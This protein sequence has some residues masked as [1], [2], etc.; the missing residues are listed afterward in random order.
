MA[1]TA[2][3]LAQIKDS[4][5]STVNDIIRWNGSNWA[6]STLDADLVALEGLSTTGLVVR[7][8][9]GAYTTRQLAISSITS[10][11]AALGLGNATGVSGNPTISVNTHNSTTKLSVVVATTA[12]ITLSGLQTID[13]ISVTSSNR[14]LVKNQTTP[15]QNG[16]YL[17]SSGAWS[18]D[19][20]FDTSSK[21]DNGVIV[22]VSRGTTN[23][24]KYFKLDTAPPITLGTTS[25]SFSEVLFSGDGNGIYSG[26]GTIDLSG[27]DV[28]AALSN[29][30]QTFNMSYSTTN[31]AL[32]ITNNTI[33]PASSSIQL[34][35]NDGS[36]GVYAA[37]E[38]AGIY[39]NS[40][41]EFAI[42][43]GT[44]RF[45]FSPVDAEYSVEYGT[46]NPAI[47]V[48]NDD[49]GAQAGSYVNVASPSQIYNL[50]IDDTYASIYNNTNGAEFLVNSNGVA[51]HDGIGTGT[52]GKVLTANGTGNATWEDV[53]TDGNGIYSGSGTID[54]STNVDATLSNNTGSFQIAWNNGSPILYA[55][56]D[57]TTP[58]N[59]IVYLSAESENYYISV[60]DSEIALSGIGGGL[61]L[62]NTGLKLSDGV[63]GYGTAGKVLTSDGTYALWQDPVVDGN[64]IYTG[65]G[66]IPAGT[67]ATL[68]SGEEFSIDYSNS[69]SSI[70]ISDLLGSTKISSGAGT[71]SVFVQDAII[72]IYS[73]GGYTSFSGGTSGSEVRFYEPSGSGTNYVSFTAPVLAANTTYIWPTS[74]TDGYYLK[75]NTGG[76]LEWAAVPGGTPAGSNTYIQYNNSGAFGAEAAFTYNPSTDTMT[77]SN[78]VL[79]GFSEWLYATNSLNLSA[80]SS[81]N[82]IITLSDSSPWLSLSNAGYTS[83][84]TNLDRV[85][86]S[87]SFA[88]TSAGT[89]IH[90]SLVI[91][92][93]INQTGTHSGETFGLVIAPTLTSI[94]SNFYGI[95]VDINDANA[96]GVLQS[97]SATPNAFSGP[98]MFGDV[99]APQSGA[100]VEINSTTGGF[101][102]PRMTTTERGLLAASPDGLVVY[103]TTDSK[104][105][106]RENGAWVEL[107]GGADGNGIYSGSGTI[108]TAAVATVASGSTFTIDWNNTT[109]ALHFADTTGLFT[110]QTSNGLNGVNSSSASAGLFSN[111]NY[112]RINATNGGNETNTSITIDGGHLSLNSIISP[113]S[114]SANQNNYAPTGIEA[115]NRVRLTSSTAVD[116]TGISTAGAFKIPGWV[117]TLHNI[118]TNAIT[119]KD[120]DANST[121]AYRFALGT[122]VVINADESF[123]LIYDNT[124]SRWRALVS[125]SV[126]VNP[127]TVT[128]ATLGSPTYSTLQDMQNIV[129]STGWADGGAVT[130]GGSGTV[131]VAAGT[132]LI[133]GTNSIP[134]TL[135]WTN[136]SA[137]TGLTLTDNATNYIYVDYNGGSPVVTASV[138]DPTGDRTKIY[139]ARVYRSG[140]HLHIFEGVRWT[141]ADHASLM[142]WSMSET[143][144]FA[145]VSGAMLTETG[146]R[147]LSLSS[148]V[149]WHGLARITT[150]ALNTSVADTF[151]L[152]YRNGVG[153]WTES[154]SQTQINN[155][156]YD[157][158]TGTLATLSNNKYGV[159][160]IYLSSESE[161]FDVLGQG[162]Y[163]LIEAQDAQVPSP[164]EELTTNARLIAKI[165]VLKSASTFTSV[166]MAYMNSFN[167]APIT[168][169]HGSLAGLSDDDHTQYALLAGRTGGQVL[170]GGTSSGDDMTIRSTT[171]A[172]KGSIIL[173]DQGGDVLIGSGAAST[174]GYS[175]VAAQA[176]KGA[177]VIQTT[178][179]G[180]LGG[181]TGSSELQLINS[182][183]T[184]GTTWY[185]HSKNTG[186]F[187][188][189][190]STSAE[191]QID[192][193]GHVNIANQLKIG[194]TTASSA[195]SIL[196]KDSSNYVVGVT[197]G[198]GLDLT[199]GTLSANQQQTVSTPSFSTNNYTLVAGDAGKMLLLSNGAT[200]GTL[201]IPPNSSVAFPTGTVIDMT[202]TGSGQIT[203]TPGS[204]VTINSAGSATK[205]RVQYSGTS[206]IKTA[207]DTWVLVGDITA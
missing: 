33:T 108:G 178:G 77:V 142:M 174:T 58:A 59:S 112:F 60:S 191:F 122:D 113:T 192:T 154:A 171:N 45:S 168:G 18:R 48:F 162:D 200:A 3:S 68:T 126:T 62:D 32:S 193:S 71:G 65:P 159:H 42:I 50:Y 75:Y 9:D 135:Y 40:A 156:Q 140:T 85:R 63:I 81:S 101:L 190:T 93:V 98:T 11:T 109:N 196:G 14:V 104:F 92:P 49:T 201:T 170:T 167:G 72:D 189:G 172:T 44:A 86:V 55:L 206:I 132:G 181:S 70:I 20:D 96:F 182:T 100:T 183:A 207:T 202:Q 161:L 26:S 173:N 78:T 119:L 6:V 121:A 99:Q 179:A 123:T 13:G 169:D 28:T 7:T 97:G 80:T 66:T 188:I 194:D 91:D 128:L 146:T 87:G 130:D 53:T 29:H 51:V 27:G 10:S 4:G 17:P 21:A 124:S 64:G 163:T 5:A 46:G 83:A 133:K 150:S 37:D 134:A 39:N 197:L 129:H 137:V 30:D 198:T 147:N 90:R 184:T 186:E 111:E 131:N 1:N 82:S 106:F 155:T 165:I 180:S 36:S 94:G 114:L 139:L 76:Q 41:G 74:A 118:G 160:W 89:N 38:Y 2:I 127:S 145:H 34:L 105:N 15:A 166:E 116:I 57:I 61:N 144:P 199:S 125:N 151:T 69:N 12:N 148:G 88:P 117:L 203:V 52:A 73:S 136:W 205:F 22:F 141:I 79:N 115:A 149:F 185:V 175:I 23:G 107:G 102:L 110:L 138:T 19:T 84:T 47:Y 152:Y 204:G 54:V 24:N 56:Q 103:N 25:L 16:I 157:N 67:V 187:E 158:G 120:E 8:S 31:P 143:M 164:P 153:G 177:G 35:S 195:T 95:Y 43:P 176:Y